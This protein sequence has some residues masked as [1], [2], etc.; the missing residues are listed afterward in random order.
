MC[1][2][3]RSCAV[4]RGRARSCA[5]GRARSFVRGRAKI[6]S[7]KFISRCILSYI[8][9]RLILIFFF[10]IYIFFL[11]CIYYNDTVQ[12]HEQRCCWNGAIEEIHIII[13]INTDLDTEDHLVY[14]HSLDDDIRPLVGH[15]YVT[16]LWLPQYHRAD[17]SATHL[18]DGGVVQVATHG[19]ENSL[20]S[21][22]PREAHFDDVVACDRFD[23]TEYLLS[24]L[25]KTVQQLSNAHMLPHNNHVFPANS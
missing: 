14:L 23:H 4:V 12:R 8:F 22:G 18:H 17:R 15:H 6:W 1:G 11:I 19:G 9:Y 20:Q 3:A 7:F 2:R 16:V 13:I 5:V 25:L 24:E 21:S 10:F